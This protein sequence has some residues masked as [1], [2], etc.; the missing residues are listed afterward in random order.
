VVFP[1]GRW[2]LY[3]RAK[4]LYRARNPNSTQAEYHAFILRII[5]QLEL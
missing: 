3:E 2:L 5:T 4:Q 1:T